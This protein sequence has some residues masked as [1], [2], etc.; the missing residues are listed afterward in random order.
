M[1]LSFGES[2][3]RCRGDRGLHH[4]QVRSD[5][6]AVGAQFPQQRLADLVR[7]RMQLLRRETPEILR[8]V[9]FF[10]DTCCVRFCVCPVRYLSVSAVAFAVF[11]ARCGRNAFPETAVRPPEGR[12]PVRCLSPLRRLRAGR[13]SR[14]FAR[15]PHARAEY[16]RT[17]VRLLQAVEEPLEGVCR[18][19]HL[20]PLLLGGREQEVKLLAADLR[21][22]CAAAVDQGF[23]LGR[24]RVEIDRRGHR[25]HVGPHHL[26]DDLR[27]VVP[28]RAGFAVAA[29]CA[30]SRAVADGP[31]AQENLLRVVARLG[32][33]AQELVAEPVGVAA[34][35]RAG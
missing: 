26:V 35:A 4:A 5:M 27:R 9:D 13:M 33:S 2:N 19:E 14:D 22:T 21:V 18:A 24:H 34:P 15:V 25:D 29:A 10:Q 31:V 3:T 7:Q 23:H 12:G 28:L 6:S 32:G 17:E 1:I 16:G 30:A 11:P 20:L 8:S